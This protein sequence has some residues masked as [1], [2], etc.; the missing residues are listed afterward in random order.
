MQAKNYLKF[1]GAIQFI[2]L[3]LLSE[4]AIQLL[5]RNIVFR[6]LDSLPILLYGYGIH[7]IQFVEAGKDERELE[8]KESIVTN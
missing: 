4:R 5:F 8:V 2:R 1:K 3:E 7:H 6:Q